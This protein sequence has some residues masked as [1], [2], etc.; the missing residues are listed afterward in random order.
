MEQI[1]TRALSISPPWRVDSVV[2]DETRGR[3]DIG[4]SYARGSRFEV[5]GEFCPVYDTVPKEWRHLNFFEH[6]CY[7]HAQVP[8]VRTGDGRTILAMPEWSGKLAGFTLLFESLLL[9]LC[10][11]M[12]VY[13]AAKMAGISDDKLWRMLDVYV[14]ASRHGESYSETRT[15]GMDE[16]SVAKGHEYVTLFVDMEKKRTLFVT[17]GKGR[18]TVKEFAQELEGHSAH[19]RQIEQV[20]CDMSPSFVSGVAEFLPNAEI[21]FDKFHILKIINEGVDAVRRQEAKE[22]PILKNK[23]FAVLKN[24]ANLTEKQRAQK[25]ELSVSDLN[26]KTMEAVRMREN[27]QA[28]YHAETYEDFSAHLARWIEWVGRCG[29]KPMEKTAHTVARHLD[30]ILNW[31]RSKINNGILEGLNSVLQAAKRKARGYKPKHFKTIAYLITG[32]LN[33]SEINRYYKPT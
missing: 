31:K 8:R 19:A 11:H 23:R 4:L 7:L 30:G 20:S 22:Q 29:L 2:F 28:L 13:R 6:E 21:T 12:P 16:T 25:Q 10:R 18:E 33:I 5:D 26:L 3:L 9:E 32:K 14:M 17:E 1:F 15:I 27:F 24:D